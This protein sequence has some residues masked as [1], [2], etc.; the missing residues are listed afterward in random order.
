MTYLFNTEPVILATHMFA[1]NSLSHA[2]SR[3]ESKTV[4][5]F[6]TAEADRS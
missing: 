4:T 5:V 3:N 1:K 2:H 6:S